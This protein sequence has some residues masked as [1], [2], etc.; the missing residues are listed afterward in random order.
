MTNLI[1]TPV[2]KSRYGLLIN[3]EEVIGDGN[4]MP[5]FDPNTGQQMSEVVIA[6]VTEVDLAVQASKSAF[7]M[8][9][10]LSMAERGEYLRKLAT[11]MRENSEKLAAIDA[12]DSGNPYAPMLRDLA[13]GADALDYFAGIARELSGRTLP[14]SNTGLHLTLLEPYGV[15]ARIIPFNHPLMF[16]IYHIAAPLIAGNT[17]VLKAPDQT[18]VSPLE[19]GRIAA[20]I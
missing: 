7:K 12:L 17:V 6:G 18:P 11:A 15:V 1:T 9:R 13:Y 5:V 14:A 10:G 3:G 19:F 2:I 16:S 4:M 8:W 20:E